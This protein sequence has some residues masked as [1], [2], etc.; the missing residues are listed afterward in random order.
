V[1]VTARFATPALFTLALAVPAFDG[2]MTSW[3]VPPAQED[4]I[5]R[6]GEKTLRA[7]LYRPRHPRSAVLLVHGL[8]PAGRRHPEL[9]RLARLFARHGRLVLVPH[10]D[11][12]A[13]FH[14]SGHEIDEVKAALA[15]LRRRSQTVAVAGFSFGAGPALAAAADED[16][17]AWIGSF[18]GYA[19]LRNVILFLTTGVHTFRGRRYSSHPEE[20]NRWKLASL[21]TPLV[22]DPRDRERLRAIAAHRLADPSDDTGALAAEFGPSGRTVMRL[23]QSRSEAQ[24]TALVERLSP[25][26]RE[27]LDRLSAVA[28]ASRLRARLLIA[29]G[30]DDDSI[31]FTESLR[32]ADAA[33]PRA[34]VVVLDSFHHTGPRPVWRTF[35]RVTDAAALLGLVD[36]M[37]RDS[38]RERARLDHR[39]AGLTAR[40]ASSD[41]RR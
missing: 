3:S 19:D 32:L 4:I 31:P 33:G 28:A 11:G 39:A 17:L 10:F 16:G 29:H 37:L 27:Q 12:L 5:V 13:D 7:D 21:L 6:A 24:T 34:R 15:E 35:H 9:V 38:P 2:W 23:I 8:S 1:V 41:R 22:D 40:W 26:T 18:G 14:L 30:T 20:Y 36:E 25:A